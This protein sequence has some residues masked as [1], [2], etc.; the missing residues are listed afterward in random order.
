MTKQPLPPDEE[1]PPLIIAQRKVGHVVVLDFE[2]RITLGEGA[3]LLRDTIRGLVALGTRHFVLNFESVKYID[4]SG[5]GEMVIA[6]S[7]VS[8]MGGSL[9]LSRPGKKVQD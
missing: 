3:G 8:R 6:F 4:S 1:K 2:G 5:I 9:K 7:T